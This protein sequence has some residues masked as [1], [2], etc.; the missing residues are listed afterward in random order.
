MGTRIEQ[1]ESPVGCISGSL[2]SRHFHRKDPYGK[3]YHIPITPKQS[4]VLTSY[5]WVQGLVT[6]QIPVTNR[7]TLVDRECETGRARYFTH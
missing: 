7:C 5:P 2:R 3:S 6:E 4:R 1:M